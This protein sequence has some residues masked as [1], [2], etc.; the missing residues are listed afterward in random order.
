[1][2]APPYLFA[3]KLSRSKQLRN[4]PG[5]VKTPGKKT[6]AACTICSLS[7]NFKGWGEV[8]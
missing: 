7:V 8:A 4:L 2:Q 3:A 1:M 5:T 6:V